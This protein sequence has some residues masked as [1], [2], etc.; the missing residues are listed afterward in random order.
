MKKETLLLSNI[1]QDF[2]IIIK[3]QLLNV[4]IHGARI[5]TSVQALLKTYLSRE[6]NFTLFPCRDITKFPTYIHAKIL[7][8]KRIIASYENNVF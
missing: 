1:K 5:F 3:Y 8:L 4:I 7:Y 2:K 6:M